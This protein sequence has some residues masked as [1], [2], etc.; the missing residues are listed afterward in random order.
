MSKNGVKGGVM[1]NCT[2]NILLLVHFASFAVAGPGP[3]MHP[4][5]TRYRVPR[6]LSAEAR[7]ADWPCFL[8]PTH[9]GVSCET[10]ISDHLEKAVGGMPHP[11]LVWYVEKGEGYSSPSI[12]DKS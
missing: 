5:V 3:A 1:R 9:D 12:V 4:R 6:E 11:Q 2:L 7:T 10:E 8:G